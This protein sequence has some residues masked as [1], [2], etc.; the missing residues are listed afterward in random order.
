VKILALSR[1]RRRAEAATEALAGHPGVSSTLAV[2]GS[3]ADQP[4]L[5]VPGEVDVLVLDCTQ[6]AEAELDGLARLQPL[7][8]AMQTILLGNPTSAAL[9][10]RA[11]RLGVREVVD[12]PPSRETL[13]AAVRRL[14][15]ARGDGPRTA[16]QTLAFVSCKGG[17]G[18]TFIAA[19]LGYALASQC[20]RK[21]LLIDLNLQF[22]D[23]SLFVSDRHPRVTIADVAHEIARVDAAYL[24]A[25]AI[26]VAPGF[27]VLAAPNDPTQ[28]TDVRPAHIE[29]I[30]RIARSHWDVV[31]VDAGRSLDA[32]SVRALDLADHVYPVLQLTLPFVRDGKRLV[33]MMRSL[34]YPPQKIRPIVNRH[35]RAGSLTLDDLQRTIGAKVFATIPNHYASAA[36]SVNQGVPI[37]KLHKSSPVSRALVQL[38]RALAEPAQPPAESVGWLGRMLART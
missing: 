19:N 25:S 13:G 17:A 14:E 29:S 34:E 11:L 20:A 1:D 22:G 33:D 6:D 24:A 3:L 8:P 38:A 10:L 27:S 37:V 18:S 30:L 2:A 23:A 7:Y 26:E 31:I 28:A 9:L 21:V 32:V 5:P 12:S 15:Q 16:A 36:D 35:E 4:G